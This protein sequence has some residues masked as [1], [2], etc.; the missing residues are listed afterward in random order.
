MR[1]AIFI[2]LLI[3]SST[4]YGQGNKNSPVKSNV[5]DYGRKLLTGVKKVPL[6]NQKVILKDPA[7]AKTLTT[8]TDKYGDFTFKG[9]NVSANY[10][11]EIPVDIALLRKPVKID[12]A[13]NSF[14]I[15]FKGAEF[16][17]LAQYKGTFFEVGSENTNFDKSYYTILW[18]SVTLEEGPQKGSNYK[19]I[20]EKGSQ[21]VELVV[22]PVLD[23]ENF[24]AAMKEYTEKVAIYNSLKN[25]SKLYMAKTDGTVLKEFK[26]ADNTFLYDLLE[27]ELIALTE[28][29]EIDLE[30]AIKT[31]STSGKTELVVTQ[32]IH[33][34]PGSANIETVSLSK[35]DKM[36]AAMEKNKSM[37][38]VISSHTDSRG[39][40]ASNMTLSQNR[41]QKVMDYF[42]SKG[43]GKARLSAQGFGETQIKNRCI[44]GIDCTDAE[45]RLN[46]R[47][48]FRFVK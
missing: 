48:E 31:F 25:G 19:M 20:L 47:T 29:K 28:D 24:D 17:E 33:Y 11:I 37:K 34:S 39:D 46:R 3:F 21:K 38:L 4:L 13:K 35:L 27:T 10:K 14:N 9:L 45:H 12:T 1:K 7:N 36:I 23:D 22:Y 42:I 16:P 15:D 30:L 8:T 18:S 2:L 6:V 26:K 40:D 41:A 43:I 32:D 44:N 5:V